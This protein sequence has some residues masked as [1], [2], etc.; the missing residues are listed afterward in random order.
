MGG[1][2]TWC[3]NYRAMARYD[4]CSAGVPFAKFAGV[5][6][7]QLPCLN[8]IPDK[9]EHACYRTPE[10]IAAEEA[11]MEE[12]FAGIV[13][14]RQAIVEFLGPYKKGKSPVASGKIDCPMCGAKDSLAFSRA[15]YN[16]HIHAA[17]N[18]DGCVKWME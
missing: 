4:T 13:K 2:K 3:K 9:C 7:D 16:G 10:E 14:A 6:F 15:A 11:E 12:R 17:C 5:K 8:V 18:T 1:R